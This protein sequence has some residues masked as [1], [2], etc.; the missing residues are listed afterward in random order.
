MG[1]VLVTGS[2]GFISDH[3]VN[4]LQRGYDVRAF[5][6]YNSFGSRGWRKN[7]YFNCKEIDF[8]EIYGIPME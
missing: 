2:D 7:G 3:L 5:C 1:K 6:F 8:Y 4:C